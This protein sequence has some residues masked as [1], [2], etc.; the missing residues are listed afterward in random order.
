MCDCKSLFCF[1]IEEAY[2][3][4]D[5]SHR[6]GERAAIVRGANILLD[7]LRS[8]ACDGSSFDSITPEIFA[9]NWESRMW[10]ECSIARKVREDNAPF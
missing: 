10:N 8:R 2:E 6:L 7:M 9:H 1:T 4:G 5:I 3:M